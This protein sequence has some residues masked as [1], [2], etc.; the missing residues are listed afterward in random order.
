MITLFEAL[1]S[2]SAPLACEFVASAIWPRTAACWVLVVLANKPA[3]SDAVDLV[4]DDVLV[5]PKK[6]DRNTLAQRRLATKARRTAREDSIGV[7]IRTLF[8]SVPSRIF[9]HGIDGFRDD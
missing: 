1:S 2:L 3:P 7:N 9:R 6:G 4:V 5:V 8:D